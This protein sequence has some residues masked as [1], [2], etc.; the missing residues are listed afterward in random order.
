MSLTRPA[1]EIELIEDIIAKD[2]E[3]VK[4]TIADIKKKA[5][6]TNAASLSGLDGQ[7]RN[8]IQVALDNDAED[9]A[10]Y[11]FELLKDNHELLMATDLDG[12]TLLARAAAA[13]TTVT[14]NK[15]D[16][17]LLGLLLDK[18]KEKNNLD[19]VINGKDKEGNT[20]LHNAIEAGGLSANIAALIDHGADLFIVNGAS[21]TSF[22]LLCQLLVTQA[23]NKNKFVQD[24]AY[25]KKQIEKQVDIFRFLAKNNKVILL[26]SYRRKLI[27][28]ESNVHLKALYLRCSSLFSL[29]HLLQAE[30]EFN[31]DKY[32]HVLGGYGQHE[33][34][35][36]DI[37]DLTCEGNFSTYYIEKLLRYEKENDYVRPADEMKK[38][39]E[40]KSPKA[41]ALQKDKD[42]VADLIASIEVYIGE[43]KETS[44]K[45][46][47]AAIRKSRIQYGLAIMVAAVAA[48]GGIVGSKLFMDKDKRFSNLDVSDFLLTLLSFLAA[49]FGTAIFVA[50]IVI[51]GIETI[52]C[53][54]TVEHPFSSDEWQVL[55]Q[56]LRQLLGN[57]NLPIRPDVLAE[58][59][60][61]ITA[62]ELDQP[63]LGKE[64]AIKFT[65]INSI[66]TDLQ[67][68]L[69]L[70][71]TPFSPI[72]VPTE[73]AALTLIPKQPENI[74]TSL[75]ANPS[76]LHYQSR[77]ICDSD[78]EGELMP[79]LGVVVDDRENSPR[80][81]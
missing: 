74:T 19:K 52:A 11:L 28:D 24:D 35:G 12:K 63:R 31:F 44:V 54:P 66:L 46:D 41:R 65:K 18:I 37:D 3:A 13:Q 50:L 32:P 9:I 7:G 70:T 25:F 2:I 59:D 8:F 48:V 30:H 67:D 15:V 60:E 29:K 55:I 72:S 51:S 69:E 43:L 68:R 79:L 6:R 33:G 49:L 73:K 80:L 16:V 38:L 36:L 81:V 23:E 77:I 22:D 39:L 4:A 47:I 1:L 62:L 14:V 71:Q 57:A 40:Y 64:L 78:E 42:T 58:L 61:E 21:I 34:E 75:A 56:K 17:T 45:P 76:V 26:A 5:N 27:M 10:F 20:A 53:A